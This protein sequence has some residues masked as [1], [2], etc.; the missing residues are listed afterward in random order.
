MALLTILPVILLTYIIKYIKSIRFRCLFCHI[1]HF[2]K[3]IHLEDIAQN[4][5]IINFTFFQICKKKIRQNAAREK[6]LV[7]WTLDNSPWMVT[8]KS[9]LKLQL[10]NFIS[11]IQAKEKNIHS[12]NM[13][14]D[15]KKSLKTAKRDW[16]RYCH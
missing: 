11:S 1:V 16:S 14:S 6:K 4:V 5:K 7:K 10:L 15:S 8:A 9:H 2:C 3:S 13:D 12:K